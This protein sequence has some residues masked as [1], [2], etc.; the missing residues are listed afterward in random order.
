MPPETTVRI[1]TEMQVKERVPYS[2][3][4]IRRMERAGRFPKRVR[5]GPCRVGWVESEVQDWLA[6]R[7]AERTSTC[8]DL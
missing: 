8:D 5:L 6:E 1:L 2:S 7:L 3:S 4:H